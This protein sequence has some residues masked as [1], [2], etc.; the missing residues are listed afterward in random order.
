MRALVAVEQ[1]RLGSRLA[2]TWDV[3][4]GT[5]ETAVPA[6]SLQPL[7][8]NAIKHGIAPRIDGGTVIIT[9]DADGDVVRLSVRDDGDG[10]PPRWAEGT[11]LGNLRE[12]LHSLYGG[13][14]TLVVGPGPGGHVTL[15]IP[16]AQP[17]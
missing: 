17:S 11:G 8:E 5:L 3:A 14:A 16:R 6:M 9:A 2:V 10:F 7:V 4:P 13:R 1:R 15:T 12:R